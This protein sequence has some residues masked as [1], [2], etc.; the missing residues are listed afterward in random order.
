MGNRTRDLMAGIRT[1]LSASQIRAY[2]HK[3]SFS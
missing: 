1:V 3:M 2:I